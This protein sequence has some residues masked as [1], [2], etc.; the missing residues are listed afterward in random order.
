MN[1]RELYTRLV[2]IYERGE[3]QAIVRLL[4]E[5]RFGLTLAEVLGGALE[6]LSSDKQSEL[7]RMMMRLETG[8]PIQHVL[9]TAVFCGRKFSVSPDV[10]I[11]RPETEELVGMVLAHCRGKLSEH[12]TGVPIRLLDIGTGSGCIAVTLALDIPHAAVTAWDVSVKAL[13]VARANACRL[14]AYVTFEEHDALSATAS[15]CWDVIVSNPPYIC[16]EEADEMEKNVLSYEPRQAL[17]VP[18][19]DPLLFYRAISGMAQEHLA[20]G[21]TVF[22]EINPRFALD[23]QELV[24]AQGFVQVQCVCDQYGKERFVK[25]CSP[26]D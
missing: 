17:F 8:E 2:G 18:N 3:A 11:P 21:G 6:Q 7:E 22:F 1:F 12:E 5:E 20:P 15:G 10:L 23:L 24:K 14:G 4:L 25:F 16:C 9:G 13:Q 19:E 26:S